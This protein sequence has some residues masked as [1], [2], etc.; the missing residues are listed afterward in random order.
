MKAIGK[1]VGYLTGSEDEF[2]RRMEQGVD[3][4]S[5]A[6]DAVLSGNRRWR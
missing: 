5:F 3:F 6:T 4:I 2:Q 1:R